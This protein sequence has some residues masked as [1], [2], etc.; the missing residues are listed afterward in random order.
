MT[1]LPLRDSRE[2]LTR[3]RAPAAQQRKSAGTSNSVHS[4]YYGKTKPMNVTEGDEYVN[5][6]SCIVRTF[7]AEEEVFSS[8]GTLNLRKESM[9]SISEQKRLE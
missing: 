6:G 3:P 1:N 5:T 2:A 8:I 9:G 7:E 4:N